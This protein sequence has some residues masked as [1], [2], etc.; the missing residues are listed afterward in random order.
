ME[1]RVILAIT[2]SLLVIL[3]WSG[4]I[5]KLYP[6]A[7]QEVTQIQPQP[8][9]ETKKSLTLEAK[10]TTGEIS[11][12]RINLNNQEFVFALPAAVLKE[13]LFKDYQDN[14]FSLQQGFGI[15][16]NSLKFKI[17][18]LGTEPTFIYEDPE[19]R[20]IK[21]FIFH[22]AKYTID[23]E[24]IVQNLSSHSLTLAYPLILGKIDLAARQLASSFQQ[25]VVAQKESL[26]RLNLRRDF[27][28]REDVKFMAIKDR[29]FCLIIQP[30]LSGFQGFITKLNNQESEVGLVYQKEIPPSQ[31]VKLNFLVYLGPQQLPILEG[32][33][34]EWGSVIHYGTFDYISRLLLKLLEFFHR[35]VH[36]W[37]VAIIMLSLFIYFILYPLSLKQMRSMKRMQGLQPKIEGLRQLY[38]DNP[39]RLNKET[40]ELYR[41]EKV[42][43]FSGCL[44]MILQIPIFFA[45]YQALIRSIELKGANFL[46]I[47]DLSE[48]DRL[49]ML[50]RPLPILGNEINII[51][52]L[53]ML[54]M[55]FQQKISLVNTGGTSQEQQRLML[56]LF[57]ILFGV[58]FYHMPSGLVL[59]WFINTLLMFVYQ[60]RIKLQH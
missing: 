23:L 20:I 8:I 58:I 43:P 46:W 32:I 6:I 48:P 37:G 19:K 18:K 16:G 54:V 36:N 10:E 13:V 39:Q 7:K 15:K 3:A 57:P 56:I 52:L 59:Y 29:Y 51:P 50:S 24:I 17:Q 12:E 33:N 26:W 60:S 25:V 31:E 22:N 34:K 55:F 47:K 1:R 14:K 41:K 5:S 45:L 40:L 27:S 44:P 11:L 35:L 42:N 49:M 30:Y 2:L 53:M 28:S 38:K 9:L 21:R 4:L